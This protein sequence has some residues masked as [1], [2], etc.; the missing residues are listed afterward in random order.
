MA[1]GLAALVSLA[2]GEKDAPPQVAPVTVAG[3]TAKPTA[4]PV[5]QPATLSPATITPRPT[6]PHTL[7]PA[8]T[9]APGPTTRPTPTPAPTPVPA[10]TKPLVQGRVLSSTEEPLVGA[11]V[12]VGTVVTETAPDGSF[13]LYGIPLGPQILFVDGST[14]AA[15]GGSYPLFSIHLEVEPDS[16]TIIERPIYLPFISAEDAVIVDP[17]ANIQVRNTTDPKLAQAMVEVLSGTA[18]LNRQPYSGA[19][20]IT[21][22][23]TDRTPR[24]LPPELN[25]SILITMQPAGIDLAVPAPITLPN[26]DRHPAG[27]ILNLWSLDHE[28]GEFFVAGVGKVSADGRTVETIQ[29]GVRGSS[30]HFFVVSFAGEGIRPEGLTQEEVNFLA[31]LAFNLAALAAGVLLLPATVPAIITAALVGAAGGLYFAGLNGTDTFDI[32]NVSAD[33]LGNIIVGMV[34]LPPLISLMKIELE[35]AKGALDLMGKRIQA[36]VSVFEKR[37]AADPGLEPAYQA[38]ISRMQTSRSILAAQVAPLQKEINRVEDLEE[39]VSTMLDEVGPKVVKEAEQTSGLSETISE[40][41]GLGDAATQDQ[42]RAF[43]K[44]LDEFNKRMEARAAVSRERAALDPGLAPGYQTVMLRLQDSGA[45]LAGAVVQLQDN[46]D[47]SAGCRWQ[48]RNLS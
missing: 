4:A 30:W 15:D 10:V 16:E 5:S 40:F 1:A 25:P 3:P 42:R 14:A 44:K 34:P 39:T 21:R 13:A 12:R 45:I 20:S 43:L 28:T 47:R 6:T 41:E 8:T 35:G 32:D 46:I 23:P 29:G 11:T 37:A 7:A 2:C 31:Q 48:S 33:E 38:V 18:L 19:L 27:A 22:V 36:Q 26:V 9:V 24:S 17:E